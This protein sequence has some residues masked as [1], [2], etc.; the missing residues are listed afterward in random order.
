MLHNID[1][2]CVC[3]TELYKLSRAK[4]EIVAHIF[5]GKQII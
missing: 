2:W 5:W 4:S 3:R 1:M